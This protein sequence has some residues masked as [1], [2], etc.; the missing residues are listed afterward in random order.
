MKLDSPP[1]R[2]GRPRRKYEAGGSTP[3]PPVGTVLPDHLEG[4]GGCKGGRK[5]GWGSGGGGP[6][7]GLGLSPTRVCEPSPRLRT[8]NEA[9]RSLGAQPPASFLRRSRPGVWE[10][11]RESR[12]KRILFWPAIRMSMLLIRMEMLTNDYVHLWLRISGFRDPLW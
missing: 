1:P 3:R 2:P 7:R 10:R 9:A 11:C 5:G 6:Q 8:Y 12:G 4:R